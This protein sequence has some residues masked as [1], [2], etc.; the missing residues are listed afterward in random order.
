MKK[1]KILLVGCGQLGSRHLQ[2]IAALDHVME[3][4]VIDNNPA[5]IETGK[6][7]LAQLADLNREIKFYWHDGFDRSLANGD[8]CLI[9]TQ[10]RGRKDLLKRAAGEFGYRTFMIEKVVD[11]SVDDYLDLMEYSNRNE[12]SVWV[13]CPVRTYAIHKYIKSRLKPGESVTFSDF[14]GNHGL[15]CNGVHPADLFLFYDGSAE[16]K[17][18]GS[19]V[20][21][22]LH[23]SKRGKEIMDLSGSLYGYTEKGSDFILSFSSRHY[24]PEIFS[25]TS[26]S[27]RYIVDHS[28][29]LAHESLAESGWDWRRVPMEENIFVSHLSKRFVSD[30]LLRGKCELPTLQEAFSAHKFILDQLLPHFNRLLGL[31]AKSCPIT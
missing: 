19:R 15:G 31:K 14:G 11:Q 17:I 27:C 12:L 5:S 20:D 1:H 18:S 26:D 23:P 8:L 4:H 28:M 10:A 13:N 21:P 2:A 24:D 6:A 25:I 7:R 9:A 16:I 3:V 29:M 30:I 22:I